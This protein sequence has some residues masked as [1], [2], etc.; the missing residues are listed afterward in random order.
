L[1]DSGRQFAAEPPEQAIPIALDS[2]R[3]GDR[4]AADV[5]VAVPQRPEERTRGG[6]V[7]SLCEFERAEQIGLLEQAVSGMQEAKRAD[8]SPGG[9]V[10][11]LRDEL[12]CLSQS[13]Q[14]HEHQDKPGAAA[15]KSRGVRLQDPRHSCDQQHRKRR[16]A[17]AA[18][19]STA[20]PGVGKQDQRRD[21]GDEEEDVVEV[22]HCGKMSGR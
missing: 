20:L 9:G 10:A 3:L 13:E 2:K 17:P 11:F 7:A 16:N 8:E 22:E 6:K 19:Q 4:L 14:G 18:I 5:R 15:D 12:G 1:H 21:A